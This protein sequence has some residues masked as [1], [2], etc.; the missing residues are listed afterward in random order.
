MLNATESRRPS[1]PTKAE[2]LG[3][4]VITVM[5]RMSA[6]HAEQFGID[7]AAISGGDRALVEELF[8]V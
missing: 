5:D 4:D 3:D 2:L 6:R 7:P 8:L 1:L